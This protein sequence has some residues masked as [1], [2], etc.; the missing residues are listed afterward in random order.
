[1]LV[2][3]RDELHLSYTLTGL[4][5][6]L[7]AVGTMLAGAPPLLRR[8]GRYRLFWLSAAGL[9]AGSLF[10]M[11]SHVAALTLVAVAL[12]GT[13]DAFPGFARGAG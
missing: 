8:I 6:G 3:L 4:H 7:W 1:M 12:M 13:F 11:V 10:L 5:S 2:F 9:V